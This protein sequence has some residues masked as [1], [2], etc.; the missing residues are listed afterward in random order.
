MG[1]GRDG[2]RDRVGQV[3]RRGHA[4]RRGW[5]WVVTPKICVLI[6]PTE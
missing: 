6:D 4:W 3:V 5:V 2:W 1:E